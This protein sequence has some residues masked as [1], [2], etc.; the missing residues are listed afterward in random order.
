MF[1]PIPAIDLM[2]GQAVRLRKGDFETREQVADNPIDVI[3]SFAAAGA[4]RVHIVDLDGARTGAP[5]NHDVIAQM[6]AAVDV[7]VQ[8][9]GGLRTLDR[10]KAILALGADRAVVGTSAAT[11]PER[12][13]EILGAAGDH[14]VVGAD[15]IDGFVATHG[16]QV[17][18]GERVEDF[19]IRMVGLGAQ[20]FLFTDV[21]RDGMLQGCNVDATAAFALA[22]GKPV[23]A[24]GGV[25]DMSD[26]RAL[27]ARHK[28]GIEAVV[29]GKSLYSGT[30]DLGE[31]LAY[32]REQSH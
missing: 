3:K 4:T 7:P 5:V 24:S 15:M 32:A 30:L 26:I 27:V 16:W 9:G 29:M 2:G 20:R 19:G 21:S 31:A 14:I 6:I 25:R 11:D 18:S 1:N 28:D 22:V 10:V 13:A 12:I 17:S 23:I 8:V